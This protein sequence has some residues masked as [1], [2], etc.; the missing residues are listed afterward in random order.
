MENPED[1]LL[2][3]ETRQ[4][5]GKANEKRYPYFKQTWSYHEKGQGKMKKAYRF[6]GFYPCN[7]WLGFILLSPRPH[8]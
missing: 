6:G 8:G 4:I 5:P 3:A 7:L 1:S 2:P